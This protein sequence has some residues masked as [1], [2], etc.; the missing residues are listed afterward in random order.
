[1]SGFLINPEVV[2]R[3]QHATRGELGIALLGL[4]P[5]IT[6]NTAVEADEITLTLPDGF[7]ASVFHPGVGKGA[8]HLAIR[9]NGDVLV[10]RQDGVL[11]ALRDEDGDGSAERTFA[12]SL[13]ITSGLQL[14]Q[15]YVYFSDNVS[16]SRLRLD[17]GILPD[18]DAQT[19]VSGFLE[20]GP[21]AT[22]DF[23]V[24]PSGELFVNVGAPS[25]A[26]QE[27]DREPGSP[28]Q[29]PC[30]DLQRQAG[31]WLFPADQPGQTQ[32]DGQRY[33]TGTRNIVALDW[34]EAVSALYF[35][36][37]GRDQLS[38]LW[39]EYFSDAENAEMP[40]EEFHR[41]VPGANYGWPYTFVDPATGIR[42][43]AP[44]YG[45]NG[46][47]PAPADIYQPPLHAYPAHWAPNDLTFYDGGNFPTRYQGGAFIAW[48]GSWNRSP[49][50]QDGYRI[51]FQPMADGTPVG[52][53]ENF[54]L[55]FAGPRPI[56]R[57][58]DAHYRPGGLA[59][60]AAGR[61]YVTET[62]TGRIWRVA[63]GAT[64]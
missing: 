11:L 6:A 24:N 32:L 56:S 26:C 14:H 53:P 31:I 2:L 15:D 12:R 59:V 9:D 20:Q 4:T 33:V 41:A 58:S 64:Q 17:D 16:V 54:M 61:L 62:E 48:R 46:K 23:T 10:S 44:E 35:A 42:L 55:G 8:R 36:M 63:Y 7:S 52:N 60:D 51:T 50:P 34:N 29:N 21:H 19:I 3:L 5:A 22:K 18:E 38:F 37:H 47:T 30:P 49:A 40:A 1:M 39:P 25:N 28:G 57:S 13:A 43:L 27:I 45:G